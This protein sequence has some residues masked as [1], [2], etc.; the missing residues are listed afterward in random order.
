MQKNPKLSSVS[1]GLWTAAAA[2]GLLMFI[3]GTPLAMAH[4]FGYPL[5]QSQGDYNIDIAYDSLDV[6]PLAGE[7]T[8][9]D[10]K[11]ASKTNG[12]PVLFT[13]VKVGIWEEDGPA[14]VYADIIKSS[15]AS[16]KLAYMFPK[17]GKYKFEVSYQNGD[18]LIV[19]AVFPLTVQ[20][21]DYEVPPDSPKKY[22]TNFASGA[23]VGMLFLALVFTFSDF[24]RKK[25][26][27]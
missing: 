1:G 10:F 27:D 11:L 26:R 21:A 13:D 23:I 18:Q 16:T 17:G 12:E 14:G 19:K 5:N 20:A 24:W 22:W 25:K 9:F 2:L 3:I 6:D 15:F 4:S 7:T 8:N